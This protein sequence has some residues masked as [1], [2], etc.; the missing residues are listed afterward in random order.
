MD[1][2]NEKE[3]VKT[4]KKD[5]VW[6]KYGMGVCLLCLIII[7]WVA[8]LTVVNKPW[9]APAPAASAVTAAPAEEAA[10]A[11]NADAAE[12][13]EIDMHL[14]DYDKLYAS[15][16]PDEVVMTVGGEDIT[17]D[18][19]FT[20]MYNSASE[21]EG[22]MQAIAQNYGEEVKWSDMVDEE[23]SFEDYVRESAA[24]S[25]TNL[26]GIEK[27]AEKLGFTEDDEFIKA[28][29]EQKQGDIVT[30]L[31]E[32][33]TEEEFFAALREAYMSPAAY[34]RMS[35]AN[36]VY[37][38]AFRRQFGDNLENVDEQAILD[39][40]NESE[41]MNANHI[42]FMTIDRSTNESLDDAAKAEKLAQA[43]KL[44]KELSEIKDVDERVARF[45][46][47]K[48]EYDEDTGKTAYPD[49]YVFTPGQM[50][51]EFE[52][53]AKTQTPYEI[54]APV[55]TAYGYHIIMALPVTIDTVLGTGNDGT[56]YTGRIAY[57]SNEYGMGI[58]QAI[59]DMEVKYAE[60]FELPKLADFEA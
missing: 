18:E 42:L 47:L 54:Y 25:V 1:N 56:P 2:V 17:W 22:Y 28:L 29:E 11:E 41:Y 27:N 38:E 31:G 19:Y 57:A 5:D 10:P 16:K 3:N 55:E 30:V 21:V 52:E 13:V 20:F 26:L 49:G 7:M 46:E 14:L 35:H 44:V 45:K 6:K 36:A 58:A 37:A 15:H 24:G 53:A 39:L 12:T 59:K 48:E 51:P 8:D 9:E 40:I 34:E 4:E 32:D 33:G 43:E 23:S 50:V 60:G